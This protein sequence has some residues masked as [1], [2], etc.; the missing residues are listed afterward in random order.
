MLFR[1]YYIVWPIGGQPVKM[2]SSHVDSTL[3]ENLLDE[4]RGDYT[5]THYLRQ[6]LLDAGYDEDEV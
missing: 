2:D 4:I 5:Y 3:K 6:Q 1:S